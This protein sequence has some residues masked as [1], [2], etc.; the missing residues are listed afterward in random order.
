MRLEL[1]AELHDVARDGH[2]RCV[3]E[4]AEALAEDPVTHIEQEVELRLRL[5]RRPSI[6]RSNC[7][8]QR[9]PSPQGAH[10]PQDSCM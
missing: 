1:L 6:S 4:G 9:V 8:I 10:L 3:A 7:T 2:G 5:R